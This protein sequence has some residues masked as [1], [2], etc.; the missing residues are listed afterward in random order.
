MH[1]NR[2]HTSKNS[3]SKPRFA[4]N[5][6]SLNNCSIPFFARITAKEVTFSQ[7]TAPINCIKLQGMPKK[8]ES[9]W[10]TVK[11]IWKLF[12]TTFGNVRVDFCQPFSLKVCR[13]HHTTHEPEIA[14]MACHPKCIS[15]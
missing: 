1:K 6:V 3:T 2:A 7:C 14:I 4:F 12:S 9:F 10:A 8:P 13:L 11:A 5:L 15:L